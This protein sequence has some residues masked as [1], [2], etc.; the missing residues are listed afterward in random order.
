MNRFIQFVFIAIYMILPELSFSQ[1]LDVPE[2][3]FVNGE[4]DCTREACYHICFTPPTPGYERMPFRPPSSPLRDAEE[5]DVMRIE[6]GP[7][8]SVPFKDDELPP[9]SEKQ[10]VEKP[11]PQTGE[12]LCILK[13][14]T[15][16]EIYLAQRDLAV[17]RH[18]VKLMR[19]RIRDG[20]R[21]SDGQN[22]YALL[23]D[24]EDHVDKYTYEL[25]ALAC[26]REEAGCIPGGS[27]KT[28]EQILEFWDTKYGLNNARKRYYGTQKKCSESYCSSHE[29]DDIVGNIRRLEEKRDR[30]KAA[31][32]ARQCGSVKEVL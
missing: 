31:L 25:L 27:K 13:K 30:I 18:W 3:C 10:T 6:G 2:R 21:T 17:Y 12:N 14:S 7:R 9:K 28:Q 16:V 15:R 4:L 5:G 8:L 20:N 1:D 23:A 32:E 22:N 29:L 24:Y 26:Y 19:E 11:K